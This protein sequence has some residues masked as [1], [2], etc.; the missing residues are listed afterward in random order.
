[1]ILE[2]GIILFVVLALNIVIWAVVMKFKSVSER[3]NQ[4][5]IDEEGEHILE[6]KKAYYH[7]TFDI[8]NFRI[9]SNG[10]FAKSKG[11]IR[12]TDR[13]L[14]FKKRLS[15]KKIIIPLRYITNLSHGLTHSKKESRPILNVHW[16]NGNVELISG[17]SID[18][19][20]PH[21]QWIDKINNLR[22]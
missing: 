18:S 6:S 3:L 5:F 4:I 7:G 19:G 8:Q 12:L 22:G 11:F 17:F 9:F 10:L 21:K 20:T 2:I 15:R 13:Y 14:I 16:I 1:M